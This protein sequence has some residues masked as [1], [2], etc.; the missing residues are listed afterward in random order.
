MSGVVVQLVQQAAAMLAHVVVAVEEWG[1]LVKGLAMRADEDTSA[2]GLFHEALKRIGR[3]EGQ[4][5]GPSGQREIWGW[6]MS[7]GG[8]VLGVDT[9]AHVAGGASFLGREEGP[10]IAAPLLVKRP[11]KRARVSHCG[12]DGQ[13]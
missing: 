2:M 7:N 12:P 3:V 10:A 4:G 11:L 8:L 6:R 13:G 9:I 1:L 5:S